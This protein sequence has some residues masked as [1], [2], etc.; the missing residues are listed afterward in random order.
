MYDA[1]LRYT[2]DFLGRLLDDLKTSGQL[3]NT[4]VVITADHGEGLFGHGYFGHNFFLNQDEVHVPLVIWWPGHI[5]PQTIDAPVGLSDL[6]P[7]ILQLV[8][9]K[10]P[11]YWKKLPAAVRGTS[12]AGWL[13]GTEP[14]TDHGPVYLQQFTISRGTITPDRQ[15]LVFQAVKGV[16]TY[17]VNPFPGPMWLWHNLAE[18]AAETLNLAGPDPNA[19]PE[20]QYRAFVQLQAI[21]D[22]QAR[23]I[24][25]TGVEAL[26]YQ[27]YMELA[28][29]DDEKKMLESLGYFNQSGSATTAPSGSCRQPMTRTPAREA[30]LAR[31]AVA[32]P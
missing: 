21:L 13:L 9:Q 25:Q 18:D 16:T 31:E 10:A 15:K 19:L 3:D 22:R 23:G 12:L 2:D 28:I 17:A 14:V 11:A 26:N 4:L 29:S 32:G 24:D 30:E 7:T 6:F 27:G 8:D 5:A 1:Q 20:E